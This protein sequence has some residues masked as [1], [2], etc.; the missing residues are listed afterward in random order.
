MLWKSAFFIPRAWGYFNE[1][2]IGAQ[3]FCASGD[4]PT[5]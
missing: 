3:F 2:K 4:S 1:R 5:S